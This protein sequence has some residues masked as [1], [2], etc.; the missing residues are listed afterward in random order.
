MA[1]SEAFSFERCRSVSF[2]E[3]AGEYVCSLRPSLSSSLAHAFSEGRSRCRRAGL[4]PDATELYPPHITVTGF[5]AAT[6]EE[7]AEVCTLAEK[8]LANRCRGKGSTDGDPLVVLSQVLATEASGYVLVAVHA[9]KVAAFADVLAR[10]VF[11][12]A[13]VQLRPKAVQHVSLASSRSSAEQAQIQGIYQNLPVLG[14]GAWDFVVSRLLERSDVKQLEECG[15]A[16]RFQELLRVPLQAER[17]APERRPFATP[18]APC[19]ASCAAPAASA[20][21][22]AVAA[23]ATPLKRRLSAEARIT[24]EKK[25][26]RLA[27]QACAFAQPTAN[28]EP[29]S[30][31]DALL[32][33]DCF[34]PQ[35]RPP[36]MRA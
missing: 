21:A 6:T 9:P 12:S 5:F 2:S 29:K 1:S 19:T 23:T 32:P 17:L 28:S 15:R 7:A 25:V 8:E 18:P 30:L 11:A 27:L 34:L 14:V 31:P 3:G 35:W 26:Q 4:R 20:L 16:H 33:Q 24:P 36:D 10:S 13:G 22:A